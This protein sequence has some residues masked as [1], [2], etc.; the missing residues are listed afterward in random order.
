MCA[1]DRWRLRAGV[2]ALVVAL[3]AWS[4]TEAR[5]PAPG[6]APGEE[7]TPAG[8]RDDVTLEYR[9]EPDGVRAVR[10]IAEL[11][12]PAARIAALVCDFTN[13]PDLLPRRP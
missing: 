1:M 7:W 13:Y 6:D 12:F 3:V 2:L 5:Q 8:R 10:A 11:P 9:D 4:A